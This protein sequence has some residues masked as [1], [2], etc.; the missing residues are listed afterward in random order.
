[1]P[2]PSVQQFVILPP[3]GLVAGP[4]P[5]AAA[6][7]FLRSL[8]S[9]AAR[10]LRA[11]LAPVPGGPKVDL[12]VID[13]IRENGAKLVEMAPESL[14]ALRAAEPGVRVVPVVFYRPAIAPRPVPVSGPKIS[15][16]ALGVKITLTVT[17]ASGKAVKGAT[18][19]AFTNFAARTGLQA[20]TNTKGQ[21]SF[22]F[23]A[24]SKKVE[25]LYVFPPPGSWPALLQNITIKNGMSVPVTPIDLSFTD[26]VRFFYQGSAANAGDGVKVAVIDTGVA[27][28]PDLV[29][30]GGA[31]TVTGE[32]PADFGDNGG[33]G[34]GTHVA[35]IIAARGHAPTGIRGVAPGVT[36]RSYR[37]FGKN[38]D[39][40]S[41]FAIAKAID[42]AVA[43]GCDLINMS[44]GG[45]DPDELTAKAIADARAAGTLVFIANGNDSRSPVSFPA[46]DALALAVSAMGR[47]GTFPANTSQFGDVQSPFGKDKS[48]FIASFSNIGP[49]TDLTGPGV[50][51]ISTVPKGYEVMDGTSMAC[52]AATGAA[53]RLLSA[54]TDLLGMARSQARSDEFAKAVFAACKVRGF[55]P[56]FEGQG[57]ITG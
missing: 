45:G 21:V 31:N 20:V 48:D 44:L 49:E 46:A 35:G 51:V 38:S 57:L 12:R 2:K 4:G 40:A 22:N 13:S 17:G 42:R 41:N 52:P 30:D 56:L 39:S 43:D 27:S 28:H 1:M 34:H 50:G 37:V 16:L 25:R 29:I 32:D 24:A 9:H 18:V 14:T 53:A 10:G 36:L 26:S 5:S 33:E 23:G 55:G 7:P 8:H 11:A 3:Q 19:V 47:K 6:A 54:R 15:G